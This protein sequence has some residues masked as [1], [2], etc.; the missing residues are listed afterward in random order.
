MK[1]TKDKLEALI[2]EAM[3]EDSL[4]EIDNKIEDTNDKEEIANTKQ[5][6]R[7]KFKYL[8]Q[9]ITKAKGLEKKELELF[10]QLLDTALKAMQDGS[11]LPSLK[12]ALSKL[13]E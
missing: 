5:K 12:M 8:Y 11:A 1:L 13:G 10:N 6:L 9:N 4:Y 7:E 2:F 3:S